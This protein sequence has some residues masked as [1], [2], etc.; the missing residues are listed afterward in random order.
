MWFEMIVETCI[1]YT[2]RSHNSSEM[3]QS[4]HFAHFKD[5]Y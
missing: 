5:G 3:Y 4:N 1:N 2:E